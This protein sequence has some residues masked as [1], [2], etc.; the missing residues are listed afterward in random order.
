MRILVTGATG[1]LGKRLVKSLLADGHDLVVTS[2]DPE[3]AAAELGEAVRAVAWDYRAQPLPAEAM[4]GVSAVYHLMG[5]KIG[6]G[7]WTRRKKEVLRGSRIQ[8][9][10]KITAALTDQ[11]T[12]FLCASAIGIYPGDTHAPFDETSELGSP[13]S[14]MT[15]LCSDWEAAAAATA[16]SSR[17][18]V[19]MRIG[20]VLGETGMLAPLVPLYRLGLGGPL[21]DGKQMIPWVHAD[22]LVAMFRFVLSHRELSG[23]VNLVGPEPVPLAVFSRTLASVVRRPHLLRVP[24]FAIRAALGEASALVLSSYNVVPSKLRGAGFEFRFSAHA[25]ALESVVREHYS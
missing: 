13:D 4:S 2:R 6:P 12:D 24:G 1:F 23:P 3:R 14:F 19:S 21:G 10:E 20:L 18:H 8:S 7:R 22:D 25:P 15:R 9:T 16:S 5:E 11:V 17:R